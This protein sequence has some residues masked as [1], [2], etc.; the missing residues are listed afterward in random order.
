MP[1]NLMPYTNL[2]ELNL[3][4]IIGRIKEINDT[5]AE[6]AG[7]AQEAKLYRDAAQLHANNALASSNSATMAMN[8]AQDAATL[9]GERAGQAAASATQAQQYAEHIGDPVAGLVTQWLQTHVDP[10]TGYVIDDTL[11]IAGAAADA[12]ATGDRIGVIENSV[13]ADI[14][15]SVVHNNTSDNWTLR[16][17]SLPTQT[18]WTETET[19][20]SYYYTASTDQQLYT[21][22]ST[23]YIQ[24][25]IY[26]SGDFNDPDYARYRN[27]DSNL[28][29]AENPLSV[30]AGTLIILTVPS[31][32]TTSFAL[33]ELATVKTEKIGRFHVVFNNQNLTVSGNGI[34]CTFSDATFTAPSGGLFEI[35]NLSYHGVQ[36]FGS[37]NDY[38]GPVQVFGENIVGG[39]HG[40]ETT[41]SMQIQCDGNVISNGYEGY[42]ENI[43]VIVDSNIDTR[44]TRKSFYS[45]RGNTLITSSEIAFISAQHM[46]SVFGCGII[47][48]NDTTTIAWINDNI[49]TNADT[50]GNLNE[51]TTIVTAGGS[52]ISTRLAYTKGA[53]NSPVYF[54][55]YSDRKKLY[56]YDL[57]AYAPDVPAGTKMCSTVKLDFI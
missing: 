29:T 4:W 52:L 56:Y 41:T 44:F 21:T 17:N 28:P 19:Y 37:N 18:G 38:I 49:L 16:S 39:K 36:I 23:S 33:M 5:R 27:T 22:Y 55:T 45:L 47:S 24:L 2:H 1:Y 53:W 3:D 50:S 8:T 7:Y 10:A 32:A 15:V 14:D 43:A 26:P 40:G 12:K 48:S 30:T 25:C 35:Q 31:A 54:L 46:S 42:P 11:T 51:S 9:A 6:T 34:A 57:F 20:K 13:F